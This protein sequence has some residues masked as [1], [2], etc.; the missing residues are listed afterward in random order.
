MFEKI[1]KLLKIAYNKDLI[2][3]YYISTHKH[4]YAERPKNICAKQKVAIIKLKI[5]RL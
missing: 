3:I 1:R 2:I 4:W 5:R